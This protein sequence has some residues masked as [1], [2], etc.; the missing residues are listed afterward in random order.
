MKG[1]V[2]NHDLKSSAIGQVQLQYQGKAT[3]PSMRSVEIECEVY[4]ADGVLSVHTVCPKCRHS[5]WIDGHN[6]KIEFDQQRRELRVESFK[7]NWEMSEDRRRFGFGLCGL[8]LVYD[9][10]IARDA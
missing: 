8:E 10:K 5:S 9:G 4:E 1:I 7:C 2:A 6:K 3:P